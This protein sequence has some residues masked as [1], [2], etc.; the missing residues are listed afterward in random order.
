MLNFVG[1]SI[2]ANCCV[3]VFLFIFYNRIKVRLQIN[4]FSVYEIVF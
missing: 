2:Q 3:C 4:D 1:Y